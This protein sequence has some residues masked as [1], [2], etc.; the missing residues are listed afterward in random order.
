MLRVCFKSEGILNLTRGPLKNCKDLFYHL[1][2][3]EL[4]QVTRFV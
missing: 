2:K 4:L 1:L 3:G